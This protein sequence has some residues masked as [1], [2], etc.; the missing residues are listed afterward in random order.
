V[1]GVGRAL[2]PPEVSIPLRGVYVNLV[3]KVTPDVRDAVGA[4]HAGLVRPAS[5]AISGR[6]PLVRVPI[7]GLGLGLVWLWTGAA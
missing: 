7:F 2:P 6:V 5:V 3:W 4:V 1:V